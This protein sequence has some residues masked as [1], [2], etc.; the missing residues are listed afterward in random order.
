MNMQDLL[1]HEFWTVVLSSSGVSGAA[2][3]GFSKILFKSFL[4]K[5][6]ASH[7]AKLKEDSDLALT[8]INHELARINNEHSV[9][10]SK[11]HDERAKIIKE[12]YILLLASCKMIYMYP[13][14]QKSMKDEEREKWL[15]ECSKDFNNMTSFYMQNKLYFNK[16][17]V[18]K[19]DPLY[20]YI[21]GASLERSFMN[22][23]LNDGL[24][25]LEELKELHERYNE[26]IIDVNVLLGDLEDEF[27]KLL[28]VN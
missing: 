24:M 12:L 7:K 1:S 8:T 3:Y 25:S 26:N 18:A 13:V 20:N 28:G 23:M 17:F 4:N 5:N 16:E 21:I 19:F 6:L 27:R 10:F 15:A 14:I 11:L 9:R 22:K 2:V